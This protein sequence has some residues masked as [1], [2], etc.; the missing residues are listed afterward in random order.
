MS[1][2]M[3]TSEV[4][5][6][7]VM[8][9]RGAWA[10]N[11]PAIV[12]AEFK[13]ERKRVRALTRIVGH[14]RTCCRERLRVVVTTTDDA[15]VSGIVSYVDDACFRFEHGDEVDLMGVKTLESW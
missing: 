12:L 1:V 15:M 10:T 14:L 6:D 5:D 9:E 3:M 8:L 4:P 7:D 13:A 2:Q 11:E